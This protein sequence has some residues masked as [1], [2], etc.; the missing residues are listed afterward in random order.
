MRILGTFVVL[1][2]GL[3]ISN[4]W[5]GGGEKFGGVMHFCFGFDSSFVVVERCGYMHFEEEE[6]YGNF[7]FEKGVRF[8]MR[9]R[10]IKDFV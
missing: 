8:G 7:C 4:F 6:V 5:F 10:R 9:R 2:I 1:W 3:G